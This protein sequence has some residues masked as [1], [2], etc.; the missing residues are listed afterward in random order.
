MGVG[1]TCPIS[2]RSLGPEGVDVTWEVKNNP[3]MVHPKG[4]MM[5]AL[6]F[7]KTFGL[8]MVTSYCYFMLFPMMS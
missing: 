6:R 7:R 1:K 5:K 8:E 4:T 2:D 3:T